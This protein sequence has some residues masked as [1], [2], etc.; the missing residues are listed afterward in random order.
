MDLTIPHVD[1]DD[2]YSDDS[3]RLQRAADALGAG[4]R[5]LGLVTIAGHGLDPDELDG[6]YEAFRSFTSLSEETKQKYHRNDIWFQRG[7]TPPNTEQAVVA[8]GQP[9]FKECWFAAPETLDTFAQQAWPQLYAQNIWPTEVPELESRHM[10]LGHTLHHIG[11]ALLRGCEHH[12]ALESGTFSALCEGAAHVTR[13]LE[14]L[15]VSAE[16][17]A[18]EV[19]W[20]EEHTDFNLLTVLAGGRFYNPQ[21]HIAP[22]PDDRAGLY[23]RTRPT[24]AHPRGQMVRGRPPKGHMVAQV[25]QQL[26]ILTAGLFQATPHVVKAPAVPQWTRTSVAHFV[27]V[28]AMKTLSPFQQFASRDGAASYMPPVLAGTYALK[29][30]VDI[31]LAPPAVLDGLGYRHYGRLADIRETGEW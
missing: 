5:Q 6:Y 30:L 22:R 11:L 13:A 7:W 10:Q 1:L 20:G 14:Y 2:L 19:L 31:A 15:P 23:L 27:H 4:F 26:E 29:T 21:G 28:N 18:A 12:L 17:V 16:Q 9:D 25:G 8:A 3:A 24:P